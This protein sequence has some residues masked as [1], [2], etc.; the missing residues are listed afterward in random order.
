MP[1]SRRAR[2][3]VALSSFIIQRDSEKIETFARKLQ[4][5]GPSPRLFMKQVILAAV[6]AASIVL[7]GHDQAWPVLI[8]GNVGAI[9]LA[10]ASLSTMLWRDNAAIGGVTVSMRRWSSV[11]VRVGGPGLIAATLVTLLVR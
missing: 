5:A 10:T 7:D 3:Q 6:F 1:F 4:Y 9:F 8:G 11:A 2:R